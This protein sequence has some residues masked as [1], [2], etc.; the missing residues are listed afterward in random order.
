MDTDR[1]GTGDVCD[2]DI[3]NDSI[4]NL[5]DNCP[6]VANKNQVIYFGSQ[7]RVQV[8][9]NSRRILESFNRYYACDQVMN[10]SISI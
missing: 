9:L 1:D 8:I 7:L 3:D 5:K 4:S 6:W 10:F 2:A